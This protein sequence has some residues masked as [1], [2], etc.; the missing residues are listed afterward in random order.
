MPR[1]GGADTLV[2]HWTLLKRLPARGPGRTV[3]ELTALLAEEGFRMT[4]RTIERDLQTL[5][6]IFPLVCNDKGTPQGWHWLPGQD[7]SLP[8]LPLADAVSLQFIETMLRP[9]LPKPVIETLEGRF[10]QARGRLRAEGG[11]RWRERLRYVAPS[12]PVHPPAV[13][14]GVLETVQPAV[15]EGRC[16]EVDYRRPDGGYHEDLLLHPLGLVQRGPVTYL[17]ATAYDYEDVRLYA[18]HRIRG[19]RCT[20]TRARRVRDFDLDEYIA[21]GGLQFGSGKSLRLRARV[22]ESLAA[23]LEETPI[24]QDQ[25]LKAGVSGD[26][27]L[28]ATVPESWQLTWWILQQG[29]DIEVRSPKAL[30]ET[31]AGTLRA[32]ARRYTARGTKR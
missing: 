20:G 6:G 22:S 24:A 10:R 4:R 11:A 12:L 32:A 21:R 13:E 5:A 9:L 2:R 29:A 31:I 1:A 18:V 30:R 16:L 14:P 7:S 26:Y 25:Q 27:R 8:E 17:V 23:I 15:L 3:A 28:T 19:A